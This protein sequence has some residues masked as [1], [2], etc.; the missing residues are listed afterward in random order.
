MSVLFGSFWSDSRFSSGGV[1]DPTPGASGGVVTWSF[2]GAGWL[3]LS[4][5]GHFTGT[6]VDLS[7]FLTF[8]YVSVVR[9]AFDSW[10]SVANIEF[11]QVVDGGGHLGSGL[12]G[13]IR[14]FGGTGVSGAKVG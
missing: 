8:D 10:A 2:A 11:I 13:N 9:R 3:N 7:T 4:S 6:S 5:T 1:R 12:T 14:I